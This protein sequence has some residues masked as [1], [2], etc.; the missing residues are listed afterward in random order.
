MQGGA[1]GAN[2]LISHNNLL[3]RTC[4]FLLHP[5]E[6]WAIYIERKAKTKPA[7]GDRDMAKEAK[8][9]YTEAQ[10]ESMKAEYAAG[11]SV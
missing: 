6:S 4:I 8:V 1:P 2:S 3:R 9:N 7:I 5:G 10:V 11:A